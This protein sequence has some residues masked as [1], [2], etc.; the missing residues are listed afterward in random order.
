MRDILYHD[1]EN[2]LHLVGNEEI[3]GIFKLANKTIRFVLNILTLV[4]N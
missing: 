3:V 2:L 4:V 1:R